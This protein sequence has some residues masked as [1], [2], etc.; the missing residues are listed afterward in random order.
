[1]VEQG[2]LIDDT[3]SSTNSP[4]L[5]STNSGISDFSSAFDG[6]SE[7]EENS[8]EEMSIA[9]SKPAFKEN[10]N[11]KMITSAIEIEEQPQ[12]IEPI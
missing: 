4:E 10:N 2:D 9:L 6:V 5:S 7:R 8:S 11:S 1:M 12:I 3:I